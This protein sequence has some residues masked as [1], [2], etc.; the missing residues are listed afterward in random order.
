MQ[1]EITYLPPGCPESTNQIGNVML[2]NLLIIEFQ[3]DEYQQA[4][5]EKK[6]ALHTREAD[7]IA[8]TLTNDILYFPC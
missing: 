7:S 8:T 2:A 3:F 5:K 1:F 6:K 4:E